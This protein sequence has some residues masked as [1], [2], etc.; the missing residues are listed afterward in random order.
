VQ[1]ETRFKK[2][3]KH[4]HKTHTDY[5]WT[6][7]LLMAKYRYYWSVLEIWFLKLLSFFLKYCFVIYLFIYLFIIIF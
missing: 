3:T 7:R 6:M 2:T 4:T 5:S 1:C